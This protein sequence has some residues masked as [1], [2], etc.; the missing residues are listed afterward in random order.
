VDVVESVLDPS[1]KEILD[2]RS[3][4]G[5]L[6]ELMTAR[7][8][9][10][11]CVDPFEANLAYARKARG[12]EEVR[13]LRFSE[14]HELEGFG[15]QQFDAV[16]SLTQ[17][18][19]SHVL[20]P[21]T[22]LRRVYEVLRPG[23][24]LLLH[25]KDVLQ[26]GKLR[27]SSV[28]DTGKAHQFH[29]TRHTIELLAKAVGFE[30]IRCDYDAGRQSVSSHVLLVAQRPA[31]DYES[32]SLDMLLRNTSGAKA[33]RRRVHQISQWWWLYRLRADARRLLLKLR[34]RV[35]GD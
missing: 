7:G 16:T 35:T 17:H 20:S 8:A 13:A 15:D 25:E 2:L 29:F 3:R 19:L 9:R 31:D 18:L 21:H 33:I 22:L 4:T 24:Y 30:V 10:V 32:Q 28:F 12:L 26:P 6:A 1:G 27:S 11:V 34:R 14:F 5:A 23:G